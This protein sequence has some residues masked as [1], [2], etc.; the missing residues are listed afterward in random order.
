MSA[1]STSD[2]TA[3]VTDASQPGSESEGPGTETPATD[4]TTS[5]TGHAG[6]AL[7]P[8]MLHHDELVLREDVISLDQSLAE[9]PAAQALDHDV[10][11]AVQSIEQVLDPQASSAPP[12][13]S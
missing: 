11:S 7:L 5:D 10:T 13:G 1:W 6:F 9:D 12:A 4:T 8:A 3:I 2:Y